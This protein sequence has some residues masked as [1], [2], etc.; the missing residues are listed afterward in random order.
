MFDYWTYFM[1]NILMNDED[2]KHIKIWFYMNEEIL[3]Y[4]DI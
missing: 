1:I 4:N 3:I 2:I